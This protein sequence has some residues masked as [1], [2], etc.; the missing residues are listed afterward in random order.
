MRM[1]D[2]TRPDPNY[3]CEKE[4]PFIGRER[5]LRDF[6]QEIFSPEEKRNS[7]SLCELHPIC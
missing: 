5:L 1:F 2:F 4:E 3:Y 7:L 6:W